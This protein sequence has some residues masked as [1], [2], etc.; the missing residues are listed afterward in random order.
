MGGGVE[1]DK[2]SC[3]FKLKIDEVKKKSGRRESLKKFLDITLLREK[4][5][6]EKVLD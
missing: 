5:N 1:D 3:I 2:V 6:L 4:A